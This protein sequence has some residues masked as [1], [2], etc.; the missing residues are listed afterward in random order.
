MAC[1]F[2]SGI[3][4]QVLTTFRFTSL[5]SGLPLPAALCRQ[6]FNPSRNNAK[7]RIKLLLIILKEDEKNYFLYH[8]YILF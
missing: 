5:R 3:T 1:P 4:L 7:L 8:L 2:G 6:G